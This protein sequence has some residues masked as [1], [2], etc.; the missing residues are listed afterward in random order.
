[1]T[2]DGTVKSSEVIDQEAV[3]AEIEG[4][5]EENLVFREAFRR[6]E[7]TDVDS[8][9]VEIPVLGDEA[10]AAGVVSEGSTYPTSDEQMSKTT[11][12]HDK[13]GVEVEITYESIQDSMLDVV[14]LHTEDK[15]RELAEALND[16][17][18]DVVSAFNNNNNSNY[19]NLQDS[20]VTGDGAPL[21]YADAVDAMAALESEGYDPDLLIV[22]AGSK[23]DL[24][25]DDKFTH[26]TELG[27]EVIREGAFGQL[28]GVDIIVDNSG[29]LDDGHAMMFDTD[30][31]GV[32]SVREDFTSMEF[33][34]EEEN[35]RVVQVRT[36][37]GWAAIR[38]KAGVKIEA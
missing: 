24:M 18:W 20:A 17:A 35:K 13:Y 2:N 34:K 19:N 16:A 37:L 14:A 5:A 1:M 7:N 26:A 36:R 30:R 23:A 29:N 31:Y 32:E 38:P 9:T 4:V 8:N 10:D 11:V 6:V 28:A 22:S 15:A 33:E 12:S 25:V 21:D 27:D 3:R